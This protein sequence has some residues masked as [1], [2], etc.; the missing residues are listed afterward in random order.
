MAA[1]FTV[2]PVHTVVLSM[3][4]MGASRGLCDINRPSAIESLSGSGESPDSN[5]IARVSIRNPAST[6]LQ[7]TIAFGLELLRLNQHCG[8]AS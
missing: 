4:F 1:T 5:G 8:G 2:N 6:L 7:N 3:D